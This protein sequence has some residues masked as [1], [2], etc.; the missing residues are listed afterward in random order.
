MQAGCCS[1]RG[2]AQE[3]HGVVENLFENKNN[4]HT[5]TKQVAMQYFGMDYSKLSARRT[6]QVQPGRPR[7]LVAAR[8][9][10]FPTVVT[11]HQRSPWTCLLY[12]SD[13]ADE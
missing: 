12:T 2:G 3:A 1:F 11:P 8:E 9:F 10:Y 6:V 7:A 4:N 5:L 13:A